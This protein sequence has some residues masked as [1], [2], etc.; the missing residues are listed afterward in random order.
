MENVNK[1][2][3]VTGG[4]RGIGEAIVRR[5]IK[6]GFSVLIGDIDE[7]GAVELADELVAEGFQVK[8]TKLDV[9]DTESVKAFV[10][11]ALT[12]FGK[13]DVLANNAGITRDSLILRMKDEDWERVLNI[14][15]KGVFNCTRAVAYHMLRARSGRIVNIASVVGQIGNAGQANYSA[16]KAGVI[17]LTKTCAREF[18]SRGITVNAVAPGFIRT[19]MTNSLPDEIR[20]KLQQTIPLGFFGEPEDVAEAVYFLSSDAA[21]YVTGHILNVDGGMAM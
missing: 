18:A 20:T 15:L 19:K 12:E 4:A 6:G 5:L 2:A 3:L 21:R 11:L 17:G 7:V 8:G 10:D 14:N 9:T 1:V 13:I 16:S